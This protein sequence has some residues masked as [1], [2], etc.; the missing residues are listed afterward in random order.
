MGMPTHET[1]QDH[2]HPHPQTGER[3]FEI[4]KDEAWFSNIKR[5]YDAYQNFDL[6]A[7]RRDRLQFDILIS[8]AQEQHDNLQAVFNGM[9]QHAYERISGHRDLFAHWCYPSAKA[10]S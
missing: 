1:T 9:M 8:R 4:G 3:A 2:E 10:Q 5:S 7:A 6:E